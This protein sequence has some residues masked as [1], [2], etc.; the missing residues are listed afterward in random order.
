MSY[1]TQPGQ[2]GPLPLQ[3]NG[4]FQQYTPVSTSDTSQNPLLGTRWTLEDGRELVYVLAGASNLATGKLMQDAALIANHSNLV[5][6]AYTPGYAATSANPPY[7]TPSQ[8]TPLNPATVTITLGGTAVTA[9]QYQLGYAMVVDGTGA[10]QTLQIASH[11]AQS[12]TTGSVVVTLADG[13]NIALD[14]TSKIS[15]V[16]QPG[17]LVIISPTTATNKS[18]GI[19]LYPITAGNYGYLV[20]K[21]T[22]ACLS[23]ST[24]PAA[25]AP[26]SPSTGTAGAIGQTAY[27]TNVVTS[28]VIGSAV[29]GAVSAKYYPVYVNI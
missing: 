24:A 10:G 27:A 26:I 19:T 4:T 22:T 9:N 17:N 21:G 28:S 23:D 5:V 2:A 6:T 13:P 12:S 15:L 16:F 8:T 20:A 3:Q 14:T 25:G 29:Y 11:P 7:S 18:R 1:F